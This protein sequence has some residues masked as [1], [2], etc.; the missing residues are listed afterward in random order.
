AKAGQPGEFQGRMAV[1]A[2]A[3][4][5]QYGSILLGDLDDN[6]RLDAVVAGC[7][8]RLFAIDPGVDT[9]NFSWVWRNQPGAGRSAGQMLEALDGLAV[10]A[11]ALGD[12]DGD[13]TL[14]LFAAVIAPPQGRNRN[15]AD[16]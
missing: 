1:S 8:G 6:G 11:A 15:P 3:R 7:C 13:G 4:Q 10:Q 2:M 16:W 12:V 14:D 5:S 9:P